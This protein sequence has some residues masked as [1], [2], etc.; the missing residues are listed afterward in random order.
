MRGLAI[1]VVCPQE[2]SHVGFNLPLPA[3]NEVFDDHRLVRRRQR[4]QVVQSPG[5]SAPVMPVGDVYARTFLII[6][7]K[8]L[9]GVTK[10]LQKRA[11]R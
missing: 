10:K 6:E 8:R 11:A 9:S 2:F 4:P 7:D 1:A 3:A 5:L